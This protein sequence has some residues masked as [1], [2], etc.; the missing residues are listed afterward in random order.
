MACSPRRA[1]AASSRR[2]ELSTAPR[3]RARR[4]ARTTR[5]G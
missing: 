3:G 4:P 1:L 2:G 5:Q